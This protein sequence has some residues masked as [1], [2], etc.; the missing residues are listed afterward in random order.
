MLFGNMFAV[1]FARRARASTFLL[2]LIHSSATI[3]LCRKQMILSLGMTLLLTKAMV[4]FCVCSCLLGG[5]AMVACPLL[6]LPR[7][8]Q[9]LYSALPCFTLF[10]MSFLA[11]IFFLVFDDMFFIIST[12][13]FILLVCFTLLALYKCGVNRPQYV[14]NQATMRTCSQHTLKSRNSIA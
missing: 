3:Y 6:C 7:A 9:F 5:R 2:A 11:I 10:H 4:K 13:C 14:T 12:L 1:F 8:Y